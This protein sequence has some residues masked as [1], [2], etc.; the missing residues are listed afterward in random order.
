MIEILRQS[1]LGKIAHYPHPVF[2]RIRKNVTFMDAAYGADRTRDGDGGLE[3]VF[4]SE[5][6]LQPFLQTLPW[7]DSPETAEEIHPNFI[8][9]IY[10][11]SNDRSIS[12]SL[13]KKWAT[14][15]MLEVLEQCNGSF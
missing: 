13:P 4:E 8:H 1:D 2:E 12:V 11:I 3:L 9:A 5:A 14:K 6:E 7:G 10:I 15:S